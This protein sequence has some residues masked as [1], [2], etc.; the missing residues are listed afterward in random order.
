MQLFGLASKIPTMMVI[1]DTF[2]VAEI[3]NSIDIEDNPPIYGENF[4]DNAF[5][6]SP[7]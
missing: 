3:N 4:K 2:H 1:N 7:C 6:M 5:F